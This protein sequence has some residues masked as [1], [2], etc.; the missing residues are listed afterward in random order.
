MEEKYRDHLDQ[1]DKKENDWQALESILKKTVLRLSIA[2]E[3]QHTS[4]DHHLHNI[5][6]M[7]KQ[8]VN[9]RQLNNTLDE[10]SALLLK[11]EDM[12]SIEDKKSSPRWPAY[13]KIFV[14]LRA[15]INKKTNS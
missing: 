13:W 4:I 11:L 12:Q 1:L 15:S 14:S 7:V 2:A 5:R 6:S 8:Q 3:G 10:I 9:I